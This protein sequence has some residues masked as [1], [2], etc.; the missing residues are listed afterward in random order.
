MRLINRRA[1]EITRKGSGY[2]QGGRW[3]EGTPESISIRCNIQPY[4]QGD[5]SFILPEGI[6]AEDVRVVYTR[7][8]LKTSSQHEETEADTT[9]IDGLTYVCKSVRDWSQNG[10]KLSH[11]EAFFVRQDL[12]TNGSL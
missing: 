4:Q 9:I 11:Y 1:L 2:Y 10:M 6:E 3:V 7:T 12:D 5:K 8:P